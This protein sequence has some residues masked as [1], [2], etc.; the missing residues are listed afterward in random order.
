MNLEYTTKIKNIRLALTWARN[1]AVC[2]CEPDDDGVVRYHHNCM[3]KDHDR[4]VQALDDLSDLEKYV[5]P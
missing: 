2:R 1:N 3:R 4:F 5:G